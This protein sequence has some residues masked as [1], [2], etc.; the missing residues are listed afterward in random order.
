MD[1]RVARVANFWAYR[2]SSR[3]LCG[4]PCGAWCARLLDRAR[5]SSPRFS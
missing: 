1:L 4:D 2:P 5:P 3:R